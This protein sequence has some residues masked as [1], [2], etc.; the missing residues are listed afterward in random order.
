MQNKTVVML[1]LALSLGIV[2]GAIGNHAV[3]SDKPPISRTEL[4]NAELVDQKDKVA[5]MYTVELA[6][7][8]LTPRHNHPGHYFNYVLEGTGVVEEDGNPTRHLKPGVSYYI[9]SS[10]EKP[11]PWHSVWNTSKT[12]PLKTLVVLIND[13]G[14]KGTV[15]EK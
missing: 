7:G 1:V 9:Y 8:V 2:I 4:I 15:F 3:S 14:Q 10:P 5:H 13:K 11:A 6:P 12:Q